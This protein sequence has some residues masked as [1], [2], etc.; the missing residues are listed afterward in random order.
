MQRIDLIDRPDLVDA[1]EEGY[2]LG[3][4]SEK[5]MNDLKLVARIQQCILE[6]PPNTDDARYDLIY[7]KLAR[8]KD[9][10]L[11]ETTIRNI[12]QRWRKEISRAELLERLQHLPPA[13]QKKWLRW[14]LSQ[15]NSP[16]MSK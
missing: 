14:L 15:E 12:D 9:I 1:F 16:K 10:Y 3:Y 5:Q 4:L 2:L 11:A 7:E 6:A 8:C 13:S